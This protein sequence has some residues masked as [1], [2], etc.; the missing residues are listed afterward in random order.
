MDPEP[1]GQLCLASQGS[2]SLTQVSSLVL[3]CVFAP[4]ESLVWSRNEPVGVEMP[5]WG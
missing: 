2:F 1:P 5:F 4:V 3:L